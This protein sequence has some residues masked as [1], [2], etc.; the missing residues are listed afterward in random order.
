[1]FDGLHLVAKS[2]IGDCIYLLVAIDVSSR[3]VFEIPLK[4]N[5]APEFVDA[6]AYLRRQARTR[7]KTDI[8]TL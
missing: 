4:T 1:M 5:K 2:I 8:M 7:A 6:L 3:K